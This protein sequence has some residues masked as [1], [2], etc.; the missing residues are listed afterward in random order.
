[1]HKRNTHVWEQIMQQKIKRI[2]AYNRKH[3]ENCFDLADYMTTTTIQPTSEI[4]VQ[5]MLELI[6]S[7][8]EAYSPEL[9]WSSELYKPLVMRSNW[10][11]YGGLI[12]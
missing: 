2:L 4:T 6:S 9:T 3:P 10:R 8:K 12:S 7:L 1:M 11:M 5:S